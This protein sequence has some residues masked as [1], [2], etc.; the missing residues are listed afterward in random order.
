M[1]WSLSTQLLSD[2]GFFKCLDETVELFSQH[3]RENVYY[4]YYAHKGKLTFAKYIGIPADMDFG[5]CIFL[6]YQVSSELIFSRIRGVSV[7]GVVHG[8]ERFLIFSSSNVP[9]TDPDDI[10]VSNVMLDLWTNFAGNGQVFKSLILEK[11]ILY[12]YSNRHK[13]NRLSLFTQAAS[14]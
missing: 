10:S 14:K 9:L 13:L 3:N 6:N 7:A 2:Y 5:K 1:Y 11:L 8:D 4:Y 12:L